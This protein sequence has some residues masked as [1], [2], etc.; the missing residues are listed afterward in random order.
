MKAKNGVNFSDSSLRANVH[1]RSIADDS[2]DTP[3]TEDFEERFKANLKVQ[4]KFA[5]TDNQQPSSST[6]RRS[7]TLPKYP[8][9]LS[10]IRGSPAPPQARASPVVKRHTQTKTRHSPAL[11]RSSPAPAKRT[12]PKTT[13]YTGRH[14]IL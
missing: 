9:S 7:H 3:L 8:T 13:A 12:A 6:L 2:S 1:T 14:L 5:K 10:P 4:Q 11:H